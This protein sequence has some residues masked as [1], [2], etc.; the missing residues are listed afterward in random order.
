MNISPTTNHT[1]FRTA[2]TSALVAL[3]ALTGSPALADE[4]APIDTLVTTSVKAQTDDTIDPTCSDEAYGVDAAFDVLDT[5]ATEPATLA[6]TNLELELAAKTFVDVPS[7]HSQYADITWLT[8]RGIT[9]GWIDGT[10]RPESA[11]TRATLAAFI[12]RYAG[13]P[14]YTAPTKSPFKDVPANHQFYKEIT[15]AAESGL[16]AGY[17]DGTFKPNETAT[18][19][20]VATFL[21]RLAGAPATAAGSRFVDVGV[22]SNQSTAIRWLSQAGI[23]SG[24]SDHTFRAE[25]PMKRGDFAVF[26][27]RYHSKGF[28]VKASPS[29]PAKDPVA[30]PRSFRDISASNQFK[31]D[32]AWLSTT[33]I[34][35]GY[36]DGTFK[37][38]GA[39]TRDAMAAFLYRFAGSPEYTPS[40]KSPFKDVATNHPFYREISWAAASGITSGYADGTFRPTEKV[41]RAAMAAFLF[42]A[43]GNPAAPRAGQF[44]DTGCLEHRTAISWLSGAGITTGYTDGTFKPNAPVERQAMAAFLHR[45]CSKGYQVVATPWS[46][47][48]ATKDSIPS[49]CLPKPKPTVQSVTGTGPEA[50][51]AYA[52]QRVLAKGWSEQQYSCLVTLWQ[53]ESSWRTTAGRVNGPYGIPQANPGSKMASAGADWRTNPQTQINWGLSYIEGLY[54]TPCGALSNFNS[55][56]WY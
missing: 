17:T 45:M 2:V 48:A 8:N 30:S 1:R 33:G 49:E 3:V 13:S 9:T 55:R 27:H 36:N 31:T 12:Y 37:P 23:T 42:R 40:A 32:I 14:T 28:A 20:A 56:G 24:Y 47:V 26:L 11:V 44:K 52:H 5:P 53:R 22:C 7:S 4:S 43:A 29:K 41:T 38:A 21:W 54:G 10:F 25:T 35:T 19:G 39:V 6:D 15:W 50:A 34:T 16:T 51:K 46:K 18:R